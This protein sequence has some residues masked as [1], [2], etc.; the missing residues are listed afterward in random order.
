MT[1]RLTVLAGVVLVAGLSA[2]SGQRVGIGAVTATG[3]VAEFR[4]VA[5]SAGLNAY[6]PLMVMG[7]LAR[8][9]DVVDLPHGWAWLSNGWVDYLA[10]QLYWRVDAPEQNFSALLNWWAQQNPK[11]RNV[12]SALSAANVGERSFFGQRAQFA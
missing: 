4:D 8:Y 6:I 5:A 11:K 7:L 2:R 3:P 9:T 12:L 10:P 1:T